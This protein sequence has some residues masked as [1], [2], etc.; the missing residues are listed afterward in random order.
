NVVIANTGKDLRLSGIAS[1]F[2]KN[3]K[4]IARQGIDYPLKN[5]FRY[6]VAYKKLADRIVANSEATKSTML[7]SAPWLKPERIKVIYNGIDPAIYKSENTKDLRNE[8]GFAEDD[9]VIGFVGRLSIQKGVQYALDALKSVIEKYSNVRLLICGDGELRG[10]VEK[11]VSENKL[12]GK[13]H[14]AGF[15][16]DIPDIMK[17]IDVLL[18]PSLWEGFGIVLI[19]AMAAGKPCIATD[20]S[21]IPEIVEDGANGFLVPPKDSQSISESLIKLISDPQLVRQ[22]GQAGI[23]TVNQKFTIDKMIKEY[24]SVF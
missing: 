15:R 14:L 5:N 11:F 12:E 7:K 20:T 23:E 8:F 22:M 18:T 9:F 4:V 13:I 2:L 24:E 6:K 17:T 21:S 3:I 16:K 10:D 19:E 1:L